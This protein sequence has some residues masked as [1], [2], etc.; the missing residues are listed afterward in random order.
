MT[1]LTPLSTEVWF[2][3]PSGTYVSLTMTP[4]YECASVYGSTD[5][6]EHRSFAYTQLG[7]Y[8][9]AALVQGF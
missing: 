1:D 4:R 7:E 6:I 2:F 3:G 9:D 8:G 5:S